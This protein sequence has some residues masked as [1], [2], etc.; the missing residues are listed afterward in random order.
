[1][2]RTR[3]TEERIVHNDRS[4]TPAAAGVSKKP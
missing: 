2:N 3:N 4:G 1:M